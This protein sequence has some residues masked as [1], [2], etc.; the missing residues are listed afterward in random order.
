MDL[1]SLSTPDLRALQDNVTHALAE[2]MAQET[3][4]AREQ[5]IAI[6]QRAGIPLVDLGK[7]GGTKKR[8]V[9]VRYRDPSDSSKTWTGRGIKPRW[10]QAMQNAGTL[11]AARV[12]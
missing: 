7:L 8:S 6:A 1:T 12:Q 5:I 3:Q 2:R 4:L 9:A 10:V 11:E